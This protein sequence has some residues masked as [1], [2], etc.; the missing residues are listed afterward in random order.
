M[1]FL[2]YLGILKFRNKVIKMHCE[3]SLHFLSPSSVSHLAHPHLLCIISSYP[4]PPE[5]RVPQG[6]LRLHRISGLRAAL[7]APSVPRSPVLNRMPW[8]HP[9][10][11]CL[12]RCPLI[13]WPLWAPWNRNTRQVI[14]KKKKTSLKEEMI[15][16]CASFYVFPSSMK[17]YKENP[18]SFI[19][20]SSNIVRRKNTF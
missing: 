17:N 6:L 16:R 1:Y 13:T 15:P 9:W 20:H 5:T 18:Y 19:S 4:F 11:Q 8:S 14:E 12:A 10:S 2:D 7:P 3:L